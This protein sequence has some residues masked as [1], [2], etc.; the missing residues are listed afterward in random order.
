M[1]E[2]IFN[3]FHP[4]PDLVKIYFGGNKIS[5]YIFFDMLTLPWALK[6]NHCWN[7]Q[8]YFRVIVS[9]VRWNVYAI[10]VKLVIL[11]YTSTTDVFFFSFKHVKGNITN[12][13]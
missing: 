1:F 8:I 10:R 7:Q 3:C 12:K 9:Y 6:K 13:E 2:I 5:G 11:G 4:V